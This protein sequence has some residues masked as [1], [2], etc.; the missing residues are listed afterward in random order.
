MPVTKKFNK[1]NFSYFFTT[2]FLSLLSVFVFLIVPLFSGTVPSVKKIT[3]QFPA[4]P[5][6]TLE[7]QPQSDIEVILTNNFTYGV[8][9]I[10]KDPDGKAVTDQNNLFYYEWN[11]ADLQIATASASGFTTGCPYGIQ[12]PCPNLHADIKGLKIGAT[13]LTVNAYK[14]NQTNII[15]STV[16]NVKV[17]S[18]EALINYKVKFRGINSK[19]A[20][21][22]DQLILVKGYN[23]NSGVAQDYKEFTV[24]GPAA[25]VNNN[26]VYT[27]Y[28]NLNFKLLNVPGYK[29]CFKGPKH[30]QKC[31]HDITFGRGQTLDFT[32]SPLDPGDLPLPQDGKADQTDFNYLWNNRGSSDPNVLAKGDLNLDNSLN[33]GDVNLILETLQTRSDE[34]GW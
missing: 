25:Q 23:N 11:M 18:E 14:T 22:S 33:M 29:L 24:N 28:I 20:N 6:Y 31:F 2:A 32:A 8:G 9:V 10:L 12:N 5:T 30:L 21:S 15:A 17:V 4:T 19:P 16:F 26:G 1:V 3:Q 13:T 34:E 7:P 27:G